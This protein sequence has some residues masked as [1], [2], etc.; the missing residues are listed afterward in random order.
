M[1][2]KNMMSVQELLST[3]FPE[4][5]A[6]EAYR[7]GYNDGMQVTIDYLDCDCIIAGWLERWRAAVISEWAKTDTDRVV[8]PP[9]PDL[10]IETEE[11][12]RELRE[13]EAADA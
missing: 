4:E 12:F 6:E 8:W 2:L 13:E 10:W 7:R 9:Q 5:T 11:G 3:D 1:E